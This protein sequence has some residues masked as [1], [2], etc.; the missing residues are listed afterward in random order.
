MSEVALNYRTLL[1]GAALLI[2]SA[3]LSAAAQSV[4]R[5]ESADGRI[6]Y[7]DGPCPT[8][9]TAVR[10]VTSPNTP[11][12]ADR[13][14]AQERARNDVKQ[15]SAA[16]RQRQAEEARAARDAEKAQAKAKKQ[17]SHCRRLQTRLRHAQEDLANATLAKRTEAQR[18]VK[19]AEELHAEDCGL[20]KK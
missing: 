12:A 9:T 7:V 20:T 2:A 17:E 19:R 18:R 10:T 16:E 5:C 13:R 4:Q 14:A 1:A 8:G 3:H 6:S 15:V 11:T